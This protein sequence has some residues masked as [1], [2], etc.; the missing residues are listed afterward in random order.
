MKGVPVLVAKHTTTTA[1]PKRT[2]LC[3]MCGTN[4]IK[5]NN[6]QRLAEIKEFGIYQHISVRIT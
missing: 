1:T 2:G 6:W 3:S 4:K 5:S